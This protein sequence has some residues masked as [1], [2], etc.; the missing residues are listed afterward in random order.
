MTEAEWLVCTDP[1]P[2]LEFLRDKASERKERLC[3][4]AWARAWLLYAADAP[5]MQPIHRAVFGGP[6]WLPQLEAAERY[7]D[8]RLDARALRASRQQSGGPHNLFCL[9]TA[10]SHFSF[11]SSLLALVSVQMEFGGPSTREVCDILRDV[12][13]N[14]FRPAAGAL[15][16]LSWNAAT[17][18]I[19]VHDIYEERAFDRLPILADALEDA[20]CDNAEILA[21]CRSG[22]AHVR[23]CW[24][25]DLLLGKR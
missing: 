10:V 25:V 11:D 24:V 18:R 15:S 19:L 4:S 8:G 22:G 21:H 13:G 20:G 1:S 5:R 2:M 12:F 6:Q 14:P 23:G 17:V 16:W 9:V 7:A 3:A